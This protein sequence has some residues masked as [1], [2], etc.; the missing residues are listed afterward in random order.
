MAHALYVNFTL[1]YR[2]DLGTMLVKWLLLK[3]Y[4]YFVMYM[5]EVHNISTFFDSTSLYKLALWK[6]NW[7]KCS[8]PLKQSRWIIFHKTQKSFNTYLASLKIT[9]LS[10]LGHHPFACLYFCFLFGSFLTFKVWN[11][12][13][14][15]DQFSWK[16][17]R[18]A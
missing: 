14:S 2:V 16:P 13:F 18:N 1:M 4:F 9:L 3:S 7:I 11:T 12:S 8:G 10:N 15:T 5:K 17:W 6:M